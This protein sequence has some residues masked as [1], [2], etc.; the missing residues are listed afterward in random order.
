MKEETCKEKGFTS[1]IFWKEGKYEAKGGLYY[2]CFDLNQFLRKL[3][4]EKNMNVVGLRFD[5][6]NIEIIIEE[7]HSE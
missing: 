1:E 5:Q 7:N 2:R 4:L 3:E 6:N